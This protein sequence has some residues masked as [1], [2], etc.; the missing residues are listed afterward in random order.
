[1]SQATLEALI[2]MGFVIGS[3]VLVVLAGFFIAKIFFKDEGIDDILKKW[4]EEGW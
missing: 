1:M 3:S 4:D 2:I